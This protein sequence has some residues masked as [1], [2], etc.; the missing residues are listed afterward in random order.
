M[1]KITTTRENERYIA[2]IEGGWWIAYGKTR[3]QA[4]KRVR[5]HLEREL[6]VYGYEA[7]S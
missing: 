7:K 4:I 3:K 1:V 5:S 2:V 6:G